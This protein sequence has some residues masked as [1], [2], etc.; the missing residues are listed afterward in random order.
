MKFQT[1][2]CFTSLFIDVLKQQPCRLCML[3]DNM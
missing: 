1:L 3:Y 2:T